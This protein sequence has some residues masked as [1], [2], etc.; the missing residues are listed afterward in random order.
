[1][2]L[3]A[4]DA[5]A[6]LVVAVWGCIGVRLGFGVGKGGR[7]LAAHFGV[8]AML[9]GLYQGAL[10][11]AALNGRAASARLPPRRPVKRRSCRRPLTRSKGPDSWEPRAAAHRLATFPA[12]ALSA[13]AGSVSA[14]P[15]MPF[16]WD[17]RVVFNGLNR[18]RA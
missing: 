16:P 9:L 6:V 1:M 8:S 17:G 7:H 18:G 13:D 10:V 3:Q 12:P 5:G 2:R 14:G 4:R 15:H 11:L